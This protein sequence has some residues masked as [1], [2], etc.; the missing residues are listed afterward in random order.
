[1]FF[2]F[3]LETKIPLREK[4]KKEKNLIYNFNKTKIK[5]KKLFYLS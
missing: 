2:K 3:F 1:M 4:V 5:K